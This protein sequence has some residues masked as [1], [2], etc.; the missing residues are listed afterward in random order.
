M[1]RDT[2]GAFSFSSSD[3]AVK[4]CSRVSF[5]RRDNE[6]EKSR[7]VGIHLADEGDPDME[8]TFTISMSLLLAESVLN[9]P[10]IE[11]RVSEILL[12][13]DVTTWVSEEGV[14]GV[15]AELL[16]VISSLSVSIFFSG[17]STS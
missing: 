1:I 11:R 4:C 5:R 6:V 7:I 8:M 16:F 2:A 9:I 3:V 12:R 10:S 15:E 13:A 14:A 17:I